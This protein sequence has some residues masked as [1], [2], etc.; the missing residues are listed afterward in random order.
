MKSSSSSSSLAAPER[1]VGGSSL[2]APKRSAGGSSLA[3]PKRS[4]GG[5]SLAAP[6]RSA[7]GSSLAPLALALCLCASVVPCRAQFTPP[8]DT[9]TLT[10]N[11]YTLSYNLSIPGVCTNAPATTVNTNYQVIGDPALTEATKINAGLTNAWIWSVAQSNFVLRVN[12][13]FVAVSNNFVASSNRLATFLSTNIPGEPK[14]LNFLGT[15]TVVADF[16][17]FL[18][19]NTPGGGGGSGNVVYGGPMMFDYD[20]ATTTTNITSDGFGNLSVNGS[21]TITNFSNYVLDE[22]QCALGLNNGS[23]TAVDFHFYD[24][25]PVFTYYDGGLGAS[26]VE[27]FCDSTGTRYAYLQVTPPGSSGIAWM[28]LFAD[29]GYSP[30]LGAEVGGFFNVVIS[31]GSD[32]RLMDA[33]TYNLNVNGNFATDGTAIQSDGSGNLTCVSLTQTSDLTQKTNITPF[34]DAALLDKLAKIPVYRWQF[35][36]RAQMVTNLVAKLA[37]N[38]VV[39]T[40]TNWTGAGSNRLAIIHAQTNQIRSVVSTNL[41]TTTNT[42]GGGAH[43][44]PMAQD[45]SAKWGGTTNGISVTDMQGILLAGVQALAAKQGTFTNAAGAGFRLIVNAQTNGFIFVPQ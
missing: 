24:G 11:S 25:S 2:A 30:G 16:Y 12:G 45:W 28:D 15:N 4:A 29:P 41:V 44:G 42:L 10:T 8:I 21:V 38:Q 35:K 6:E 20:G 3:A 18:S 27:N 31:G 7:G 23:I 1:S 22:G 37:M 19:T 43:I 13:N 14:F 33:S 9:T 34:A 5:S 40:R 26:R 32:P 39:F 36:T 17:N